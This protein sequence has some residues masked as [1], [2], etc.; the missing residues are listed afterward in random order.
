MIL[1]G[2]IIFIQI[3]NLILWLYN[4]A[5]EDSTGDKKIF[6]VPLLVIDD[7]ADNASVNSGTEIDVKTIN[8]LIRTLL[9]LFNQNTFI[10]YTA[11][12]YANIFIPTAW[13]EELE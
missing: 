1:L 6:D 4:F 10:G 3:E 5:T 7:E 11:T 2:N 9:N 12:P 8:R 13:N